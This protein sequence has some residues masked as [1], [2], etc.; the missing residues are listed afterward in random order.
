MTKVPEEMKSSPTHPYNDNIDVV[1]DEVCDA[2]YYD[3][4]TFTNE[5]SAAN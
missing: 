5:E 1:D 3:D 4:V 2:V